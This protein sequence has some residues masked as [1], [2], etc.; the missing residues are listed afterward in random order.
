[1]R[2]ASSSEAVLKFMKLADEGKGTHHG[3]DLATSC[4]RLAPLAMTSDRIVSSSVARPSSSGN[5]LSVAPETA[6]SGLKRA[7]YSIR[8]LEPKTV[9]IL[10][11]ASPCVLENV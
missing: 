10:A 2:V 9:A 8:A 4:I 1:M 6:F 7:R 5:I 3:R 11:P